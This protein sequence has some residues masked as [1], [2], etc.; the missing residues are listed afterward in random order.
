MASS[1]ISAN[2]KFLFIF[3]HVFFLA[4]LSLSNPNLLPLDLKD[5]VKS[6]HELLPKY[7]LPIGLL[8]GNVKSYSLK[9]DNSFTVELTHQCYVTIADHK[10]YYDTHIKGKL[11]YGK[12][13]DVSGIQAKKFFLWVSVSSMEV[14]DKSKMIEFHVGPFTEK[15]PVKE[16]QT[17]PICREKG[18]RE[19]DSASI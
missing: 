18:I 6:I 13:Y 14:D 1:S 19:S 16:F 9:E 3:L 4:S 2:L 12:V 15:I 7:G 17:I 8:P 11:D 5:T 10:A